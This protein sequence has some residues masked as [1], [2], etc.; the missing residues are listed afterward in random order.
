[1]IEIAQR[2]AGP[3]EELVGVLPTEPSTGTMIYLC[4]FGIACDADPEAVPASPARP[5]NAGSR[6]SARS[7][8]TPA[9]DRGVAGDQR[10]WLAL[11]AAGEAVES[12]AVVRDAVSIAALCEVAEETAAGG[13]LD[14]LRSRLVALRL[15][16]NP[17]GVDEAEEAVLALQR[18]IGAPPRIASPAHLEAV[19]A[20]TRLLEAAL[21]GEGPSPFTE[22]MKQAVHAV[23]ALTAEVE[24]SYKRELCP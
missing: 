8:A 11:D 24:G 14:D 16:E 3:G 15:T 4:A 22:A 2:L 9:V 13:D 20:A 10:T 19:G 17:P 6:S 18:T 5:S 21:G 12:R 7:S 1:M 23:E